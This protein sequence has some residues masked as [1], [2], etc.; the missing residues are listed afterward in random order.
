MRRYS[1]NYIVPVNGSPI[2]NGIVEVDDDGTIIEIIEPKEGDSELAFTE[3]H[4]GVI[5]PGFINTHCHLEL[6]NLKGKIVEGKGLPTFLSKMRLELL[7]N[8][9]R[10]NPS[11][12]KAL[13]DI[14][15]EGIVAVADICN[16]IDAFSLKNQSPVRFIN[17]IEV[18]GLNS[19]SAKEIIENAK[20]ILL[21]AKTKPFDN[22]YITPHS[23]Y[24][25]S[26]KLWALLSEELSENGI[27]SI[28]WAE[29]RH[30]KQ[31]AETRSGEL[32]ETFCKMGLPFDSSPQNNQID[33]LKRFIPANARVLFVHNTYAEEI[34]LETL[35]H[36]F[37]NS[38]FV[39]CPQSNLYIE[40]TLPNIPML[41]ALGVNITIGTDSLASSHNLSMLEQLITIHNHFPDINFHETIRWAT[42]N[43]AKALNID[44]EYGSIE[45]G[46]RPGLSLIA[47]FDFT[48]FM[49]TEKSKVKPLIFH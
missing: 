48:R 36:Y 18:L 22:S 35:I 5:V 41:K 28:H 19:D 6:S 3:F 23:T 42:F 31:F 32:A 49:P 9:A 15:R 45:V 2:R 13:K 24:L 20:K 37:P 27:I 40:K 33:I 8:E 38:S 26:E 1:A 7:Q 25:L 14:E 4:N 46:K 43:G 30:E 12:F 21:N 11:V 16:T 10:N 39:L 47:P 44:R 17:L 34:D 29:S